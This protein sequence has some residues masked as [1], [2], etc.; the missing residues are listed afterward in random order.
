MPSSEPGKTLLALRQATAPAHRALNEHG[1][2]S[3]LILPNLTYPSY[4]DI[5][6][7]FYGFYAPMERE[8][9]SGHAQ[10]L[11]GFGLGRR[12][13]APWLRRDLRAVGYG[14]GEIDRLALSDD[15]PAI[16]SPVALLGCL[17]VLDG[18][19]LGGRVISR[20][21]RRTLGPEAEAGLAFFTSDGAHVAGN[22][23]RLVAVIEANTGCEAE[24]REAVLGAA[25][26]F[27]CFKRWFDRV[28][29]RQAA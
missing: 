28:E 6:A 20:R 11:M 10:V 9:L 21:L 13:R 19:A 23:R 2:L 18:A 12:Q 29:R 7:A 26:T 1:L 24:R 27:A 16:S 25:A 15:L 3:R 5:L 22:W 8:V 17:Y 4:G 14:D